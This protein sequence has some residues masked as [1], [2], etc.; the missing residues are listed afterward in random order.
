VYSTCTI[1]IEE[2]EE[3]VSWL[4]NNFVDEIELVD[5]VK[6]KLNFLNIS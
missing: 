3:Q 2:N 5:Q 1:T 4:I 6:T